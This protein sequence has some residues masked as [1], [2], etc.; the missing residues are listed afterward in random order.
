LIWNKPLLSII[1]TLDVI[2]P[3]SGDYSRTSHIISFFSLQKIFFATFL[4]QIREF[5]VLSR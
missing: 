5:L 3:Q 2:A 4:Q 1:Q